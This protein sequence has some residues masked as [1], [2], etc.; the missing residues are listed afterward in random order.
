MMINRHD[1]AEG[2]RN[3]LL[4]CAKLNRGD[5]LLI[6]SESPQFGWYDEAGPMAVAVEARSLDMNPTLLQVGPPSGSLASGVA[7]AIAAHDCCIFFARIGDQDRFAARCPSKTFVMS[8]ARDAAML[9]SDFGRANHLAFEALKDAVD[10]V[11]L[12]AA[13]ID[14]T[15]P[16]GTQISGSLSPEA[17]TSRADVSIRRFPLGVPQPICAK[18]LSGRVAIERYLTST[19]SRVYDPPFLALKGAVFAEVNSG[20]IERFSGDA[21]C[22]DR[23]KTHYSRVAGMFGIDGGIVHSSTLR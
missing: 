3:L 10:S 9:A 23:I 15:C 14:I 20:R 6:L 17:K 19:G 13:T 21:L 12:G 1:L 4:N 5:S 8:Y 11:L 16:M 22:I 2:A 18:R 7:E